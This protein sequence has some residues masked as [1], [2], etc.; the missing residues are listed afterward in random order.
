MYVYVNLSDHLSNGMGQADKMSA[1]GTGVIGE[2]SY[3]H[4]PSSYYDLD[5]F[6]S[7]CADVL[8]DVMSPSIHLSINPLTYF[9]LSIHPSIHPSHH[10]GYT[11]H[12][13]V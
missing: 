1:A 11:S 10:Q 2:L 3:H 12:A 5:A 13:I 4:R 9:P 7:T 6:P 8:I